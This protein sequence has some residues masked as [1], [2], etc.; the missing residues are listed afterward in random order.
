MESD[1][2]LERLQ[3][4]L[5][6]SSRALFRFSA[7]IDQDGYREFVISSA[8]KRRV[9]YEPKP[10]LKKLQRDLVRSVLPKFPVSSHVF[11]QKGRDV[12]QNAQKHVGRSYVAVADL[13]SCY[14]S[15]SRLMILNA[16][17]R[18]GV[19]PATAG[20][21]TRLVSYRGRLPQGSPTSS[22]ILN[23]VLYDLDE[24]LGALATEGSAVYTRY[25]DDLCISGEIPIDAIFRRALQVIGQQGFRINPRKTRKWGPGECA[26]L[27]GIRLSPSLGVSPKYFATLRREI[28]NQ[29]PHDSSNALGSIMA[30]IAWV[31]RL[32]SVQAADLEKL[33]GPVSRSCSCTKKRD[34]AKCAL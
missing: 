25:A 31:G 1:Y 15:V 17:L 12:I 16:F 24:H 18:R 9:I 28:A 3:S 30:K 2:T 4:D 5:R 33:I 23:V 11:S 13:G 34:Q 8:A 14:P 20:L 7:R 29:R 27:T 26:I 6:V 19:E 10:W 21:L 32:S 22:A